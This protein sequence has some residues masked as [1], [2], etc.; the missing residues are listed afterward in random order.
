MKSIIFYSVFLLSLSYLCFAVTDKPKESSEPSPVPYH[1]MCMYVVWS[2]LV[3][4]PLFAIKRLKSPNL[5]LLLFAVL[6]LCT[7]GSAAFM[8]YYSIYC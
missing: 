4:I 6:D 8:T 1:A 2:F 3:E 7:L 5:H